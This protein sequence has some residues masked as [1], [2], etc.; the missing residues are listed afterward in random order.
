MFKNKKVKKLKDKSIQQLEY[1]SD[2]YLS[3]NY[4][5]G[6]TIKDSELAYQ[7]FLVYDK[8]LKETKKE[9]FDLHLFD[10]YRGRIISLDS[11]RGRYTRL[12]DIEDFTNKSYPYT[13]NRTEIVNLQMVDVPHAR[14]NNKVLYETINSLIEENYTYN[15]LIEKVKQI[16]T[17]KEYYNKLLHENI[18]EE[19]K[20]PTILKEVR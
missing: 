19:L 16:L 20:L 4:T 9:L 18:T 11:I 13:I 7:L 10:I 2:L 5:R 3:M 6:Y 17:T 1:V 15:T 12:E 8:Y 14:Q